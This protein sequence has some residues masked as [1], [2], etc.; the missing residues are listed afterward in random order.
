VRDEWSP[1]AGEALSGDDL[2]Y[3]MRDC[4]GHLKSHLRQICVEGE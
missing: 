1:G 3:L 2:E 4:V